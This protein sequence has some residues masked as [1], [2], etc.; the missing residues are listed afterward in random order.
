MKCNLSPAGRRDSVRTAFEGKVSIL[1]QWAKE[2]LPVGTAYPK[3]HAALRRWTGPDGTL[4]TWIDPTVDRITTGKYPA[5]A[6]RFVDAVDNIEKRIA[7]TKGRL[8]ALEAEV[9]VLRTQNERLAV[10]NAELIGTVE[11]LEE[12]LKLGTQLEPARDGS[13]VA[14][15]R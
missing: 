5:L 13:V 14:G 10:Q 8:G 1:E 3:T 7:R 4:A 15:E 2:G 6:K 9:A 11:G 12:K